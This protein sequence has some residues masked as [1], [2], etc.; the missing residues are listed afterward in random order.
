MVMRCNS[1]SVIHA[2]PHNL[3]RL[4]EHMT[5]LDFRMQQVKAKLECCRTLGFV[6]MGGCGKTTLAKAAFNEFAS[7][8]EYTCFARDTKQAWKDMHCHGK[9]V[10]GKDEWFKLRGKKVLI[11]LDDIS[12]DGDVEVLLDVA[13][14]TSP[15]SR[16]IVTSRDKELLNSLDDVYVYEVPFLDENDSR[17][18]FMSLAFP[19]PGGLPHTLV[20]IVEHIV[21]KCQ[22]LPL[23][24]EV[25]GKFL[26]GKKT[27]GFGRRLLTPCLRQRL[28][29]LLTRGCG[30]S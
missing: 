18:L 12:T 24:L 22:G 17:Q 27:M 15:E 3:Q 2:R 25:L 7:T 6:G 13:H 4:P 10:G 28:C 23:T 19:G 26:R 30:Q 29:N 21:E 11:V 16:F 20:S 14:D 5:G 9:A 1:K 8:F